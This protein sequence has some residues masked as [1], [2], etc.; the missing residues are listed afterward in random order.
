[1]KISVDIA[2]I[3]MHLPLKINISLNG[4]EWV[5]MWS[6]RHFLLTHIEFSC[7]KTMIGEMTAVAVLTRIH[8]TVDCTLPTLLQRSTKLKISR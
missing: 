7:A 5:K 2:E 4:S 1:M 6:K 8:V 3:S